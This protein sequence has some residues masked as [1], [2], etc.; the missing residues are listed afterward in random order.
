MG[1]TQMLRDLGNTAGG[2]PFTLAIGADGSLM[3]SKM[4]KLERD[5]LDG[6]RPA[7]FHG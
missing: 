3:A 5:D 1:G 7:L 2:L 4:G 6:W